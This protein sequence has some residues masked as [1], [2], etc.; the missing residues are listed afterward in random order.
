[1]D[2]G[3]ANPVLE[4]RGLHASGDLSVDATVAGNLAEPQIRGTVTL[5]KGSFRDYVRGVNLTN[6]GAEIEGSE[7]TLQIKTFKASAASGTV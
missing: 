4:A 3:I 1:M 5:A 2:L 6:I 7:G